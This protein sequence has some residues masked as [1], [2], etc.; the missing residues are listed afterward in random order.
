MDDFIPDGPDCA[1]TEAAPW[2]LL[3]AAWTTGLALTAGWTVRTAWA[4]ARNPTSR[5]YALTR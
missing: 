4:V 5:R 3:A 1:M 2:L